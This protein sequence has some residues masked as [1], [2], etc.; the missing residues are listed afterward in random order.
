MT[1]SKIHIALPNASQYLVDTNMGDLRVGLIEGQYTKSLDV[2][3]P[4]E[5]RFAKEVQR[6]TIEKRV[7]WG[8]R[9]LAYNDTVSLQEV[10]DD[11]GPF[12]ITRM[13]AQWYYTDPVVVG[14]VTQNR[15]RV[16]EHEFYKWPFKPGLFKRMFDRMPSHPLWNE[17][18]KE[19]SK[20]SSSRAHA[21]TDPKATLEVLRRIRDVFL[22]NAPN[23]SE[24]PLAVYKMWYGK[25]AMILPETTSNFKGRELGAG[26]E[27][28]IE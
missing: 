8:H 27:F 6:T 11:V 26:E 16:T 17:I 13:I 18:Q 12:I 22:V 25:G 9:H 23:E 15:D 1:S 24:V 28:L 7:K 21:G 19:K 20:W 3:S 4:K 14:G 2:S 5:T 10:H